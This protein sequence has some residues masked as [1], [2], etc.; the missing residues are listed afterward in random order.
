MTEIDVSSKFHVDQYPSLAKQPEPEKRERTLP[1]A[2]VVRGETYQVTQNHKTYYPHVG[3]EV[4]FVGEASNGFIEDVLR[5]QA[6]ATKA[7]QAGG[8]ML[9]LDENQEMAE[10]IERL[11]VELTQ[12]IESWTWT[13]FRG[14]PLSDP[15]TVE[16]VRG[17]PFL[18]FF[19]LT[20]ELMPDIGA[21]IG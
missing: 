10:V 15:P 18:E 1:P 2:K 14:A 7:L 20:N 21:P 8:G 16:T 5:Y 9:D 3:E 12:H 17:L 13:D 4:C 19:F 6:L 11:R